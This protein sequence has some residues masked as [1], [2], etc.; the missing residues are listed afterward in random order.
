MKVSIGTPPIETL[1]IADTGSDLTWIQCKPCTKCFKQNAPFFNLKASSTYKTLK[2]YS[3]QCKTLEG[4]DSCSR[5]HN[6]C[7]YHMSYGDHS[8]SNGHLA[9]DTFTFGGKTP[10]KEVVFGCGHNNG[11]IFSDTSMGIIGLGGGPL[12]I[13]TQLRE[14][15]KGR[16]S[17]CLVPMYKGSN[18]TSTI[19]FGANTLVSGS[20]VVSTPLLPGP[21]DTFYFLNLEKVIIGNK[22]F[23]LKPMSKSNEKKLDHGNIIIDS[24]TTLTYLPEGEFY[25]GLESTLKEAIGVESTT[26]PNGDFKLCYKNKANLNVP[27]IAVQFT[28]AK[29]ELPSSNT[30]LEV[31]DGLVC[32]TM[33]PT[34]SYVSI[35]GNL[36]Q[37]NFLISY[38]LLKKK[39]SF[40]PTDCSKK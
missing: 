13:I 33:V 23:E 40:M 22:T 32:F 24:G 17:Y 27:Y 21:V 18:I 37:E 15:I 31:D 16:F 20:C 26:D 25:D 39:I 19:N 8:Y 34:S 9:T 1:G 28:G 14:S 35:F 2:C 29:L 6:K 3:K 30:F 4:Y 5:K 36:L 12:S 11:G 38:D 10:I 7:Q